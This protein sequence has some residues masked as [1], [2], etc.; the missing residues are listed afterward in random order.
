MAHVTVRAG[1]SLRMGKAMSTMSQGGEG[2]G[3]IRW[4]IQGHWKQVAGS[5]GNN[6]KRMLPGH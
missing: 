6:G 3:L 4:G 5:L 2:W 1:Q